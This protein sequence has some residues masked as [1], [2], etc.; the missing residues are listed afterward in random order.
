MRLLPAAP[1]L[2]SGR[3]ARLPLLLWQALQ[4]RERNDIPDGG[5]VCEQHAQPVQAHA[6]PACGRQAILQ[7]ANEVL[8]QRHL[9]IMPD[10]DKQIACSQV[11]HQSPAA[12]SRP[13]LLVVQM[14][15]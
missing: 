9:R 11:H 2:Q 4:Q 15:I 5:R 7:C 13:S 10:V 8:V 12:K 6:H 1:L 3:T 14:G